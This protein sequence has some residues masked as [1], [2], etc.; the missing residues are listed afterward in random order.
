MATALRRHASQPEQPL[1]V[2]LQ[3]I[4]TTEEEEKEEETEEEEEEEEQERFCS[5]VQRAG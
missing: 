4:T 1:P 2:L 5:W 3:E